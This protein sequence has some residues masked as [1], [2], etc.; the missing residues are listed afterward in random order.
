MQQVN[1]QQFCREVS[2]I[3]LISV[4]F[5]VLFNFLIYPAM[6]FHTP[7]PIPIRSLALVLLIYT[8]MRATGNSFADFGLKRPNKIWLAVLLVLV[9]LAAKLFLV[10][11]LG[12]IL[13]SGLELPRSD[14][15]FFE[16][17]HENL[18]ALFLWL[19]FAWFAGGLAEEFIFRGF[20]MTRIAG[21][22]GNTRIAWGAALM[23]Q[24]VLF[25]LAHFYLGFGGIIT[26]AFSALFYGLFYLLA[27]R[28]LWP[29]II[30]HALWDSLGITLLYFN[31]VAST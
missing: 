20:L 21:L 8:F 27:G 4:A 10:Q 12:D 5:W 13:R 29:V 24:A 1:I 23:I 17:I 14:H 3:L 31:G 25:G 18:P 30:V 16:H 15:R 2:L 7:A 6:G 11:P 28:N 22:I 19:F 9:F 26:T